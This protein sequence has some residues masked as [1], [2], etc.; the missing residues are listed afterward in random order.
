[1]CN[2]RGFKSDCQ[3]P[4]SSP[5]A[6]AAGGVRRRRE[7]APRKAVNHAV[8]LLFTDQPSFRS[9]AGNAGAHDRRPIVKII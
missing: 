8:V 9:V 4:N 1:M 2:S 5:D 6:V 7:A 3:C